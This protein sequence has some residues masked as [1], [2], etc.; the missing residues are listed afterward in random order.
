MQIEKDYTFDI[1]VNKI[2]DKKVF[3][4]PSWLKKID[5]INTNNS[6]DFINLFS[7]EGIVPPSEKNS[8]FTLII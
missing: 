1:K 3:P 2:I 4:L 7:I 5:N 6:L 8:F